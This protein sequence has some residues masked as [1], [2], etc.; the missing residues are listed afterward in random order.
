MVFI[1]LLLIGGCENKSIVNPIVQSIEAT[2]KITPADKLDDLGKI[3]RCRRELEALKKIDLSVYNKRKLEFDKLISGA[4]LY[5]GVRKD[6]GDYTQ[7]AVDALYRF[8][9][10]KLCADISI[11]VLN[12]L[13][14]SK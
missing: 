5:S 1:F 4:A 14:A 10:D 13:S 7:S 11:D 12:N 6:V 2:S 9:S 8:R 3:E